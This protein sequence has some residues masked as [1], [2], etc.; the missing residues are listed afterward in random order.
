MLSSR[1]RSW[2]IIAAFWMCIPQAGCDNRMPDA[3]FVL[4]KGFQGA[5]LIQGHDPA[6]EEPQFK[7]GQLIYEIPRNGILKLKGEPPFTRWQSKTAICD[8]GTPLLTDLDIT[9]DLDGNTRY[10]G[11]ITDSEPI[12]L[13]TLFTVHEE[14]ESEKQWMYLGTRGEMKSANSDSD[15]LVPGAPLDLKHP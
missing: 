1:W 2:I 9:P 11:P 3:V 15:R 12:A 13:W 5:I 4:P 10:R 14:G 8:D 7:K 6:G